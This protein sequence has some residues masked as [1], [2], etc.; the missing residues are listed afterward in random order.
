VLRS[1]SAPSVTPAYSTRS[2]R[3]ERERFSTHEFL[4][5]VYRRLTSWWQVRD[6]EFDASI[7]TAIRRE[8]IEVHQA[9]RGDPTAHPLLNGVLDDG[10]LITLTGC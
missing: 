6:M 9:W 1:L 4:V 7:A 5:A 2:G 3:N 10:A 8:V